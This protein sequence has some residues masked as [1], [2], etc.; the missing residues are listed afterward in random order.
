MG[1]GLFWGIVLIVLGLS[2]IFKVI[3]DISI[4]R[5]FV[6]IMFILLGVKILIGRSAINIRSDDADVIFNDKRYTEFPTASTEYNTLFG[7]SVFDFSEAAIPTDRSINLEFNTIF[8]NTKIIL[9]PG[10]PVRIKADAV[11]GSAKLPDDNTAVFGSASYISEHDIKVM[12][13]VTIEASAVFGN[14]VI[15]Q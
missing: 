13:F 5:I 9:P 1:I 3:F 12:S 15:E 2:I 14:I 11:F 10:L 6:A 8:G 7:K 4:F